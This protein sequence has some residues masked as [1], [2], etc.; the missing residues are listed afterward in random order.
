MAGVKRGKT[1]LC[2]KVACGSDLACNWLDRADPREV[3]DQSQIVYNHVM[4]MRE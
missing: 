2:N 1:Y 3:F 4:T